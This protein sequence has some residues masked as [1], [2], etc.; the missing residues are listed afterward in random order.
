GARIPDLTQEQKTTSAAALWTLRG[1]AGQRALLG[2]HMGW[3]PARE[4]SG[5]RWLVPYLG[6]LLEDPYSAVRYIA[7]RSLRALP[8]FADFD[9]DYIAPAAD[10]ARA[11]LSIWAKWEQAQKP[12]RTGPEVLIRSDGQMERQAWDRLLSQRD[13]KSMYLQE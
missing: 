13:D 3:K 10:R 2:W 11:R 7:R 4:A 9:C 8:G 6:Q 1:D 12:D 5:E